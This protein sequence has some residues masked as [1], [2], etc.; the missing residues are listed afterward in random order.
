MCGKSLKSV[1][2]GSE[3][4]WSEVKWS[5]NYVKVYK[6]VVK[7]SEVKGS[8]VKCSVGKGWKRGVI[9]RIYMC[10]KVVK[11]EGLG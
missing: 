3:V 11:I 9:E 6:S 5:E 2:K 8:A 1:V 10:G 4:K 7:W